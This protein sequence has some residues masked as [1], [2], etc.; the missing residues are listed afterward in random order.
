MGEGGGGE[1]R[2]G[3][4]AQLSSALRFSLMVHGGKGEDI[5]CTFFPIVQNA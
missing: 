4:N 5:Y 1:V 3:D 2:Y